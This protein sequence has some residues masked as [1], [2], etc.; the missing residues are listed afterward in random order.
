MAIATLIRHTDL[1]QMR[2]LLV[3]ANLLDRSV[4]ATQIEPA[5]ALAILAITHIGGN[6][7]MALLE[8]LLKP[9]LNAQKEVGR[10][11]GIEEGIE[12]GAARGEARGGPRHS[13]WQGSRTGGSQCRTRS[14]E[15]AAARSR[16][17]F[18]R[19]RRRF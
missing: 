1:A 6:R 13:P 16:R 17:V 7:I 4:S 14:M 3:T 11:E 5:V 18:C 8:T 2:Q 15:R 12:I 9:L 10:E 19:D